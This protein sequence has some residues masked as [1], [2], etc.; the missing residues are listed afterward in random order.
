MK[1][2]AAEKK[3]NYR[4]S[5]LIF[6]MVI[7]FSQTSVADVVKIN[8]HEKTELENDRILLREIAHINGENLLICE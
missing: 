1:E 5:M 8:V 4:L 6:L 7:F 2:E 3:I